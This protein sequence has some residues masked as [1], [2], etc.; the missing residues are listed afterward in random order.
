MTSDVRTRGDERGHCKVNRR[1]VF[2]YYNESIL[3]YTMRRR[4]CTYLDI[5]THE[6][7]FSPQDVVLGKLYETLSSP[8]HS[9]RKRTWEDA[10]R[11]TR[12]LI[13]VQNMSK[14]SRFRMNTCVFLLY[15]Q[16]DGT[17]LG[18]DSCPV[19]YGA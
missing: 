11:V 4:T 6:E 14:L 1:K 7:V 3:C 2:V 19:Q 8:Q 16:L 15:L 12:F 17:V 18:D 5:L 9:D 10:A 13:I